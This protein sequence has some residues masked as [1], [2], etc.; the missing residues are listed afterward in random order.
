MLGDL[1]SDR[2]PH[3]FLR[4]LHRLAPRGRDRLLHRLQCPT[5]QC[6][7]LD[8]EGGDIRPSIVLG[9]VER[10]AHVQLPKLL[11]DPTL[12]Q[13]V[14]KPTA[15]VVGMHAQ[16]PQLEAVLL[17]PALAADGRGHERHHAI[18]CLAQRPS[19]TA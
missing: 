15:R 13:Q 2:S 17:P 9:R 18:A 12:F 4:Q 8:Q 14:L 5:N 16:R 7:V 3:C 19:D 10:M 1:F 6:R 11:S